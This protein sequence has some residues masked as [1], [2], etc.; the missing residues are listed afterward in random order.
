[1]SAALVYRQIVCVHMRRPAGAKLPAAENDISAASVLARTR[2]CVT[3]EQSIV[4][5][6]EPSCI[7]VADDTQH[8]RL[9]CR[10]DHATTASIALPA[11]RAGRVISIT[12]FAFISRLA[13]ARPGAVGTEA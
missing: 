6:S 13:C 3:H 8:R 2:A 12:T 10:I 9:A 5:A 1:V 7:N 4:V 11:V